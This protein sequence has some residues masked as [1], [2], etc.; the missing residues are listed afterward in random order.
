LEVLL[1]VVPNRTRT[2][3]GLA[4]VPHHH[5]LLA[6]FQVPAGGTAVVDVYVAEVPVELLGIFLAV[7]AAE[8][9]VVVAALEEDGR[10]VVEVEIE[11]GNVLCVAIVLEG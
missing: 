10:V 1:V 3:V 8:V 7:V 9:R 6:L 5:Y 11:E 4:D 2:A